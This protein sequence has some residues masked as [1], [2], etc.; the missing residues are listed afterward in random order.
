MGQTETCQWFA[1]ML[2]SMSLISKTTYAKQVS[3]IKESSLELKLNI[4][5]VDT[6]IGRGR[7]K[8]LTKFRRG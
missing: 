7:E 3:R 4:S 6:L 8:K 1:D 2:L 5:E